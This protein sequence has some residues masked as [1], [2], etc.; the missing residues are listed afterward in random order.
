MA[1]AEGVARDLRYAIRVLRRT[2]AF[3][4]TAIVTL[5]LVIGACTAVFSL[6]DAILLRPLPYPEPERLSL[7]E[8]TSRYSGEIDRSTWVDG[9]M[10]EAVR[11]HVPSLDAMVFA[12][13]GGAN[14][15]IG[16]AA[17][18]VTQH[19]VS[20]G[21]FRVLGVPL[22]HGRE[23]SAEEDR[24]GGP[25]LAVL[26]YDIWRR[27]FRSDTAIIGQSILLR[28]EPYVVTGV[29]AKDFRSLEDVDVWTPLRGSSGG[30]GGGT[31]FQVAARLKSGATWTQATNELA[32]VHDDAFRLLKNPPEAVRSLGVMPMQQAMTGETRQPIVLLAWAVGEIGRASCRERG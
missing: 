1:I 20:A 17:A 10:W 3:T 29:T 31:N 14:L 21:F 7:I 22:L 16:E 32:A 4:A 15:V 11:D 8:M 30:E 26:S 23:F 6:A 2:P 27:F 13:T 28:G 5:A 18:Y 12:T 25:A 9:A 24:P 19:R